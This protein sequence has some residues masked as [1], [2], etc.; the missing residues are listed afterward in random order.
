MVAPG[1]P[2]SIRGA[3]D[4]LQPGLRFVNRNPGS[5]TRLWLDAELHR[6]GI[7]PETISGYERV[8]KTHTEAARAIQSGQADAALGLEAAAQA[9]GLDFLPLFA[10]RYD[11]VLPDQELKPFA[12]LLDM[13]NNGSFRQG[14]RSLRGYDTSH[15]GEEV[16]FR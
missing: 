4:L 2:K 1:N 3:T 5:G 13:L 15:T 6:L 10:E 7:L 9:H 8:V 11:L 12:P 16:E 14:V